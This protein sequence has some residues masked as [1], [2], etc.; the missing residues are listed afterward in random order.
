[1]ICEIK[2]S[3][4]LTNEA[5]RLEGVWGVDGLIHIF[6]T[7][8]LD[9]GEWSASRLGRFTP[10][11]TAPCTRWIGSWMDPRVCLDDVEK[12][13]D[14]IGTPPITRPSSP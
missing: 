12:I 8:A 9:G 6:L 5:L 10:G 2:L 14:H 13:L 4:C 7:S 11:E 1:M 3:L